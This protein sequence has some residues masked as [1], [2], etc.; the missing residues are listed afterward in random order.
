MEKATF[1]LFWERIV[2]KLFYMVVAIKTTI[3][4]ILE[5]NKGRP[6]TPQKKT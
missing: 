4:I 2:I 6:L 5:V 3:I 1:V